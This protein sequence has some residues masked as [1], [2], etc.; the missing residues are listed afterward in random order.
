MGSI[1]EPVWVPAHLLWIEPDQIVRGLLEPALISGMIRTA[2]RRPTENK[3]LILRPNYRSAL[4][5][6]GPT[7][8]SINNLRL[9]LLIRYG[10]TS[11]DRAQPEASSLILKTI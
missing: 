9:V 3:T 11:H 1:K 8:S 10:L 7:V 5:G 6:P 4:D 2:R